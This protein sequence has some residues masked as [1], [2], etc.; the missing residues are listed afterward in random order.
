[1]PFVAPKRY[2]DL[3]DPRKIELAANQNLPEGA[4]AFASNEASE[5]RRYQGVPKQGPIPAEMQRACKHGYLASV[6]FMDAQVG[7][8]LAELDRLGLREK[9]VVVLWGDHGYQLGEHGTWNKRTNWEIAT[10]V[11]LIVSAPG[12][13]VKRGA[14]SRALVEGVDVYPTLAELAGLK[15]PEKLEGVSFVPLLSD[16]TRAWK[17]AAFSIY[18][19]RVEEL[20]GPAQGRA[21]VT[22][23]YRLVEWAGKG[24]KGAEGKRVYEL[25]DHEKDPG[26]NVN[27]AGYPENE[28]LVKRLAGELREGWRGARPG[29]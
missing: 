6:S 1:M 21:M 4:P 24:A 19:K 15:L 18:Q 17:R 14:G 11:P 22:E 26:E 16:P 25:Y 12:E 10:R 2:W 29:K 5:L 13:N 27:V 8:V 7:R 3:Y 28:G 9:T 20:G 23:R